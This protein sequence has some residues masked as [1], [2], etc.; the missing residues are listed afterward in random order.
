[1]MFWITTLKDATIT[2][3]AFEVVFILSMLAC[4]LVARMPRIGLITAYVFAYRWGWSIFVEH[5][6]N[7]MLPYLVFGVIVGILTVI[8]LMRSPH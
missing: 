5:S 8:G 1:M 3:P 4:F 2:L 6:A 7:A